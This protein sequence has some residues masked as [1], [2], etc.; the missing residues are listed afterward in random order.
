MTFKPIAHFKK[1]VAGLAILVS[2]PAQAVPFGP[3]SLSSTLPGT[4]MKGLS[5]PE[6][7]VFTPPTPI[8]CFFKRTQYR[9]TYA[10][11]TLGSYP[12]MPDTLPGRV[13]SI[14][15]TSITT[16][17]L[18]T[19]TNFRGRCDTIIGSKPEFSGRTWDSYKSMR[20]RF[21]F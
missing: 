18:C 16:V 5:G 17:I 21:R 10:C 1:L 9:D 6:I 2:L 7:R 20:V 12:K 8:A 13:H 14:A 19:K 3:T 15:M 11:I 4:G